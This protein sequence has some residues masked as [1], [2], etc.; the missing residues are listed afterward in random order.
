[1]TRLASRLAN[2]QLHRHGTQNPTVI[3]NL[4]LRLHSDD[5][6]PVFIGDFSDFFPQFAGRHQVSPLF[7]L[8]LVLET[9][10]LLLQI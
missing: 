9:V 1:M 8:F 7:L 3:S 4:V 2:K 10:D 6:C 5:L